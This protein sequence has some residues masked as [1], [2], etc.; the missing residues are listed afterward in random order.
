M[1][2][3]QPSGEKILPLMLIISFAILAPLAI[4]APSGADGSIVF[5]LFFSGGKLFVNS[6]KLVRGNAP[7]YPNEPL[8][9]WI[10]V[11]LLDGDSIVYSIK[12]DD[13]RA[14]RLE[15]PDREGKLQS[16]RLRDDNGEL[17]FAVPNYPSASK[18]RLV[19]EAG[20]TLLDFDYRTGKRLDDVASVPESQQPFEPRAAEGNYL[21]VAAGMGGAAFVLAYLATREGETPRRGSKRE[22]EEKV[23]ELG[24][25]EF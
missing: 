11:N 16:I 17:V 13:S 19:D 25:T 4:A 15:V 6:V 14:V 18:A 3:S 24:R 10:Q 8:E 9:N 20:A 21:P 12:I 5:N 2:S 23:E 22:M 7:D 1:K